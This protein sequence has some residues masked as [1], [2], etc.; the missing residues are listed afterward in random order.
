[1]R[2]AY[3]NGDPEASWFKLGTIEVTTT[4][5]V[6]GLATV[7]LLASAVDPGL[8][9]RLF[10]NSD[11]VSSG[12]FW[13]LIT[14]PLAVP[15]NIFGVINIVFFFL[16]GSRLEQ[17]LGRAKFTGLLL[18]ISGTILFVLMALNLLVGLGAGLA[19]LSVLT[20]ALIVAIATMTPFAPSFF[21]I[22]IW[23]LATGFVAYSSLVALADRAWGT[24]IAEVV[25]AI[26][27]IGY[28]VYLGRAHEVIS[29]APIAQKVTEQ[30]QK[31]AHL[32]AVPNVSDEEMNQIL[33]KISSQGM[34]SLTKDEKKKL[35]SFSKKR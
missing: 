28:I 3:G 21:Q 10:F 14:W 27:A 30:K 13:R 1:M 7:A 2:Y 32:Q 12:E 24:L 11:L 31:R 23:I 16:I 22:P 19:G 18:A 29:D 8:S 26:V 35:K 17:T 5:L 15:L 6:S 20:T 34:K 33:D 4:I 25:A 9:G